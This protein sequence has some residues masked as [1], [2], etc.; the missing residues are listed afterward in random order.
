MEK[1]LSFRLKA[2]R[3]SYLVASLLTVAFTCYLIVSNV[4]DGIENGLQF[5]KAID[6]FTLV[7]LGLFESGIIAFIIRSLKGGQ[8]LLI[9]HLVFK[10]D[11]TPYLFGIVLA[12]VGAVITLVLG[13]LLAT[14]VIVPKM[15]FG[16]R[17]LV[18]DIMFTVFINLLFVDLYA[19][20]FRHESGTFQ[21]I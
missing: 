18:V 21:I 13:V 10:N 12:G 20:M 16:A 1:P 11:G 2:Y 3:I 4:V 9:K 5:Q 6:L 8:T 14:C 19:W 7:A 15:E 17:M